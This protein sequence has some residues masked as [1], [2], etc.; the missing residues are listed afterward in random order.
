[1]SRD[2]YTVK[3]RLARDG[4]ASGITYRGPS[5]FVE[6]PITSLWLRGTLGYGQGRPRHSQTP[7]IGAVP[8]RVGRISVALV[9]AI[10][11]RADTQPNWLGKDPVQS[12]LVTRSCE[13]LL[14]SPNKQRCQK[15]RTPTERGDRTDH[16]LEPALPRRSVGRLLVHSSTRLG[17]DR[18]PLFLS[19]VA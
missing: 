10:Q 11:R 6:L 9:A 13:R 16:R 19:R 18:D 15:L 7:H 14:D 8:G 17:S 12:A 3:A 1:M 4:R 2:L 5:L